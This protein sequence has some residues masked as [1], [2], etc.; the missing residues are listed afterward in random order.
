LIR[1]VV[2]EVEV[3]VEGDRVRDHRVVRFVAGAGVGAVCDQ[4]HST[5]T[6]PMTRNRRALDADDRRPSS[7]LM[8][9]DYCR[10]EGR[11]SKADKDKKGKELAADNTDRTQ[12]KRRCLYGL[13]ALH[14]RFIGGLFICLTSR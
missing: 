14:L 9:A 4:P 2:G 11:R 8:N 10:T 5:S 12:M 1:V 7:L 3:A 6:T 13:S